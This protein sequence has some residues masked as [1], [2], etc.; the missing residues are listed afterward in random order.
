MIPWDEGESEDQRAEPSTDHGDTGSK[1]PAAPH[2]GF[3]SSQR[4]TAIAPSSTQDDRA[5]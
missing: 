3:K 1:A 5:A 2:A 4:C